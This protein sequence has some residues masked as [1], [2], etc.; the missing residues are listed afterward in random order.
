MRSRRPSPP[1]LGPAGLQ[2]WREMTLAYQL[3]PG[4]LSILRQACATTDL[5]AWMHEQLSGEPLTVPG[6]MGQSRPN[7]LLA[8]ISDQRRALAT[9]WRE[10]ALPMPDEDEGRRRTPQA[11]E[12]AQSRWRAQRRSQGGALESV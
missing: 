2:T 10:L 3:S 12:A 8:A 11:Q 7:P 4:E 5:I 1:L 6:S 9:L